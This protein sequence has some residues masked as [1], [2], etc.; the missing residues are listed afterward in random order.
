M[1]ILLLKTLKGQS[2]GFWKMKRVTKE[3]IK[4]TTCLSLRLVRNPSE[5]KDSRQAGMTEIAMLTEEVFD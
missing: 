3:F 1:L 2:I 4:K 5:K